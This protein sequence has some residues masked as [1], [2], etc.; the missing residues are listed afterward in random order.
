M[1]DR[2]EPINPETHDMDAGNAFT[3]NGATVAVTTLVIGVA[4]G[5]LA[6]LLNPISHPG[7]TLVAMLLAVIGAWLG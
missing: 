4:I 5:G 7:G 3:M 2:I 6:R 1:A